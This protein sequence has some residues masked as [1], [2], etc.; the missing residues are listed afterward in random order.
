MDINKN[1]LAI[2]RE[3]ISEGDIVFDV[4]CQ[5]D[6]SFY[7]I[8]PKLKEIH[9]FDPNIF[10]VLLEK[11]KGKENIFFNNFAL[12]NHNEEIDFFWRYGSF[13]C[14]T[15]EPKFID[16]H[17]PKKITTRKLC[18]YIRDN[19]INKIDYLKIDTEGYDFEVIKGC[20]EFISIIKYIQFEDF[21][22]FY[23]DKKIGDIFNYFDGY[24]IYLIEGDIPNYIATKEIITSLIQIR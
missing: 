9:L 4:G 17:T 5:D 23:D 22:N 15:E 24:N 18:D 2:W 13:L 16:L 19:G 20:G 14:R 21:V 10:E 3:L 1:E 6:N 7:E 12:G 11:I 8:E